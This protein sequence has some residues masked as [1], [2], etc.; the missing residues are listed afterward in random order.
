MK[1]IY[2][3]SILKFQCVVSRLFVK[4]NL[5]SLASSMPQDKTTKQ[6]YRSDRRI[7]LISIVSHDLV[8][9]L[10]RVTLKIKAPRDMRK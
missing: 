9:F 3:I 2:K 6:M 4:N 1:K 10:K 7:F 5:S 8:A